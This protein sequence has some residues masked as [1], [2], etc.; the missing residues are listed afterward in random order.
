MRPATGLVLLG[1]VAPRLRATAVTFR[2]HAQE[3]IAIAYEQSAALIEEALH[4]EGEVGLT[5]REAAE[6]SGYSADHLG[7]LVRHGKLRNAGRAGS[8][9]IAPNDL[10]MKPGAVAR[11]STTSELD[12]TQIVRSVI[13]E[14]VG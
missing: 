4:R 7:R 3:G 10:P 8:P 2:E 9:R 5:L 6:V 12:L 14:G 1:D 11:R 13:D